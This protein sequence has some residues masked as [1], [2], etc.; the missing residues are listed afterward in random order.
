MM[1][2]A[3]VPMMDKR[4]LDRRL[5]YGSVM[6]NISPLVLWPDKEA[7]P[8][9]WCGCTQPSRPAAEHQAAIHGERW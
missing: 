4:S 1:R 3:S 5:N 7:C 9:L 8:G 6:E 2:F